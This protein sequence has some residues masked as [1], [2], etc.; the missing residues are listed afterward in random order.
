MIKL[1]AMKNIYK[2]SI[3]GNYVEEQFHCN[4]RAQLLIDSK[5]RE[6]LSKLISGILRHFPWEVGLT[7]SSEGWVN[8]DELV[9]AIKTKWR[10]KQL[11]QWVSGEHVIALATLDPKG[12]FEVSGTR[13]RARYGHSIPVKIRYEE[14]R[15]VKVLYHGTSNI[16]LHSI[17]KT[18]IKPVKRL[19]VHLTISANN[20]CNVAQRH[21]G[22]PVVLT[23]DVD[24]L[25]RQGLKAYKATN[26]IYLVKYVPKEC[27]RKFKSC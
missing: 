3:C 11:Y 23:I 17:L 20:A 21:G 18:G 22:K 7:L 10:N 1:V 15:E 2:C 13:I 14:D 8:I 16:N 4:A 26:T 12:R 25:R 6:M 27:I 9:S 24:C 5:R 19:W